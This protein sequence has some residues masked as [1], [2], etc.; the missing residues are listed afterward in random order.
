MNQRYNKYKDN[1]DY[2]CV[3]TDLVKSS[4]GYGF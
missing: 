2:D 3:Y 1:E 4:F